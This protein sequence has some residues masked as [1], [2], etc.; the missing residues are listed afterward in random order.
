MKA[1]ADT[2]M[3]NLNSNSAAQDPHTNTAVTNLI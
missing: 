1:I 2:Q 3:M